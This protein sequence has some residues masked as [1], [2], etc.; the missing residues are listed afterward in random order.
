[1]SDGGTA[2][3]LVVDD[4]ALVRAWLRFCLAGTEFRIAG[5]ADSIQGALDLV[6]RRR[7]ELLLVD[8][9]LRDGLGTDLLREVRRRHGAVPS[10]VVTA[11]PAEGLNELA[12]EAG[13]HGTILKSDADALLRALRL[14]HAGGRA[15]DPS[16]P[17]RP[18]GRAVLSPREREV[19]ALVAE[20][21]TNREIAERLGVGGETVKTVVNR[22]YAKLGVGKRAEAVSEAHR[23]GLLS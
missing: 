6:E 19:L 10:L 8:F 5:E 22:V 4:D 14:V 9:H 11:S 16:H 15:F 7:P 21:R 1:M 13:A 18:G 23:Q 17:R 12:R 3:V 20:G 2:G